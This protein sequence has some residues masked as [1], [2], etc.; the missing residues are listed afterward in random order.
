L[1]A[2][3]LAVLGEQNGAIDLL[4]RIRENRGLL[5]YSPES[6]GD[7]IDAI[8]LERQR[9]LMGEGH[10]WYD[11]V[12]YNKIKNNDPEFIERIQNGGIYW[13]I[14]EAI[15]Q[16]NSLLVQNTFWQ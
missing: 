4:N 3:A 6:N 14:S 11:I 7:L 15:L 1:R 16:Q 8:F 13:P 10:R 2:E 5:N 12:R 9:E